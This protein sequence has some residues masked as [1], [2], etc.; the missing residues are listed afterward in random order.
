MAKQFMSRIK[1]WFITNV[2]RYQ[3]IVVTMGY[4]D[5]VMSAKDAFT[6]SEILSRAERYENKYRG[7][8]NE[9]TFHVYANEK[10][11]PMHIIA[12]DMYRM[13]KLAGKPLEEKSK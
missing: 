2:R 1:W 9:N 6:L 12:D 8:G 7:T 13:A 3:M 10:P 11:F 5:Y 4:S